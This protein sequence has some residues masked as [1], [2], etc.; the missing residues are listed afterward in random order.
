MAGGTGTR[1]WPLSRKSSPKQFQSLVS[2]KT[3]LRETFDRAKHLVPI[4]NIFI[5]TSETFASI[6]RTELPEISRGQ[7]IAEPLPRGTCSAIAL[8]ATFLTRRNDD[9]IIA[10][11]ASDHAIENPEEFSHSL[12]AAF[13]L[14][15]KNREKIVTIGINP[16]R[17][18]TGL[19][20]I[21][22][23]QEFGL[24]EGRKSYFIET[25]REKPDAETA[26]E[27]LASF[28]YLWN[29]G[30]FI[31]SGKNFLGEVARFVPKTSDIVKQ[32]SFPLSESHATQ[33]AECPNDPIDTAIIEKLPI[34][35]R[36]VIP[37]AI[38]WSDI[39]SWDTLFDFLRHETHAESVA[40]GNVVTIDS[41]K[42]FVHTTKEK[43]VALVGVHNLVVVETPDALLIL[44]KNE[45]AKMK[46][47]IATLE[48]TDNKKY[49]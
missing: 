1:L 23:G 10:T 47:L 48:K 17:P 44:H 5:C 4:E 3:L 35:S 32:F 33:Y 12:T 49:L 43:L 25:F 26:E 22:I 42:N 40:Q 14:V 24:F 6:T 34:E 28:E 41:E 45:A 19:G 36:I 20:Y 29:A 16:T 2:E 39:G 11:I 13:A 27:Y 46:G 8:S 15:E 30:Y 37:S 9:S 7:I 21:Q 38:K 18:D 31:F